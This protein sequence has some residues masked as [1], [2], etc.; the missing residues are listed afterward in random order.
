[1]PNICVRFAISPNFRK[2]AA[3]IAVNGK[4]ATSTI[5]VLQG[6]HGCLLSFATA[7]K[8][9]LVNVNVRNATT[10]LNLIERYPNVFK[11]IGKLKKY[12]VKLHIDATVQPVAQSASRIPFHLR[13]KWLRN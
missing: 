7:S 8:L 11:G 10:D 5:H 1:M 2:F 3:E 9:S 4:R 6:T 13:K 12:E